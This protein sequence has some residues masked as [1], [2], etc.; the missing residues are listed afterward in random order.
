MVNPNNFLNFLIF[1]VGFFYITVVYKVYRYDT[2]LKMYSPT[3]RAE[4]YWDNYRDSFI[5]ENALLL[6]YAVT[7]WLK[8]FD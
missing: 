8:A 4:V 3:E 7:L 5:N 1:A 2:W 6:T